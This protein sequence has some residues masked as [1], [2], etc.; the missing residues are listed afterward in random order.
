MKTIARS[1][2]KNYKEID[3]DPEFLREKEYK[4]VEDALQTMKNNIIGL[5]PTDEHQTN[6]RIVNAQEN[7]FN[8]LSLE[9]LLSLVY[10]LGNNKSTN[11]NRNRN[12]I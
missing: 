12:K 10:G 3:L 5:Y 11:R 6:K 1:K 8:N 2:S 7:F 4:T 9:K